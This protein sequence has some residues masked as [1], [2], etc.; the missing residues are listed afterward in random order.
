[1]KIQAR[2][3]VTPTAAITLFAGGL[4]AP[5]TATA[6]DQYFYI[7]N[8]STDMVA[9]VFA[10]SQAENAWVA[11]WPNYGGESEQFK[12]QFTNS[13]WFFLIAKHS[14]KC[15]SG[16][17]A[18]RREGLVVQKTCD[19]E[20]RTSLNL[21]QQW[22]TRSIAKTS[23]ECGNPNQ[24]F[25]G[26]RT[27]LDNRFYRY[28][29]LDAANAKAPTPPVKGTALQTW[30]CVNKF[31]AWNQANQNWELVRTQDWPPPASDVR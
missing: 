18:D 9:E 6:E 25:G 31:S 21:A 19:S 2:R 29:C 11:L 10:H 26:S 24:C 7:V 28:R 8:Q 22:K 27:I 15:L 1:M 14:G 12:K 16:S 23:D 3:L 5:N 4:I 13:G 20:D 17:T 30:R